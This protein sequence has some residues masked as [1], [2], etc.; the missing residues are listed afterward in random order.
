MAGH[1]DR[2]A[3]GPRHVGVRDRSP[4]LAVA[5]LKRGYRARISKAASRT[6][7][8]MGRCTSNGCSRSA[9]PIDPRVGKALARSR[10]DTCCNSSEA[11]VI[12]GGAG[13]IKLSRR[14]AA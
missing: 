8:P 14:R 4:E 10:P 12:I 13:S 1:G 9:L 2:A 6:I 7:K 11:V 5:Y 3:R